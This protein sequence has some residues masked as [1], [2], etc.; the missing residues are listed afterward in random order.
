MFWVLLASDYTPG[1][2]FGG[3]LDPSRFL[4]RFRT[5]PNKPL[6]HPVSVSW[7]QNCLRRTKLAYLSAAHCKPLFIS[8]MHSDCFYDTYCLSVEWR[9][10]STK[11][12]ISSVRCHLLMVSLCWPSSKHSILSTIRCFSRDFP[13]DSYFEL[14]IKRKFDK[15]LA[16]ITHQ[17]CGKKVWKR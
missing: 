2:A 17:F 1:R 13:S 7:K 15:N 4:I 8:N 14:E 9:I 16:G 11:G 5:R 12:L 6:I 3:V 10:R